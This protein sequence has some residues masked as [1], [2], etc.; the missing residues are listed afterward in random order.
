[1]PPPLVHLNN[2]VALYKRGGPLGRIAVSVGICLLPSRDRS[3]LQEYASSPR[4]IGPCYR[5]LRSK[6]AEA[7]IDGDLINWH[8]ARSCLG[9]YC[10]N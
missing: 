8:Q 1:M 7:A 6:R 9:A 10:H 5:N 4:A 2:A 3:P